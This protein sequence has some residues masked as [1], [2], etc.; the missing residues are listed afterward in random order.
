M[1]TREIRTALLGVLVVLGAFIP[2]TVTSQGGGKGKDYDALT[3]A[4]FELS[5]DGVPLASFTELAGIRSGY[6]IDFIELSPGDELLLPPTRTPPSV[7]LKRP[8]TADLSMWSWHMAT[9]GGDPA[10]RKSC[11][12]TMFNTKNDPVARYHLTDAWPA[13]MEIG[14]LKAGANDV[15]M[16]SVMLVARRID[17]QR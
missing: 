16:E 7:L 14:A 2:F 17:R 4:R 15:L 5:I 3:A 1:K 13:K 9:V 11:S 10:A 6:E 12:L 8:K